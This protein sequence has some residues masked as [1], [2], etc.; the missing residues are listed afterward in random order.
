MGIVLC[1][2]IGILTGKYDAE[3]GHSS[4]TP[5]A[6]Y[7]IRLLVRLGRGHSI[8]SYDELCRKAF[9]S[10]GYFALLS[11]QFL[12]AYGAL[13]AYLVRTA[14]QAPNHS[15]PVTIDSCEGFSAHGAQ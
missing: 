3:G 9:G 10:F 7:T 15:S 8:F 12:F 2:V 4:L 1:T 5:A 14:A 13:C 6:D 11:F